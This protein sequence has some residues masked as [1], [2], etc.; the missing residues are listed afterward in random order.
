MGK[1]LVKRHD[2]SLENKSRLMLRCSFF[3]PIDISNGMAE[4]AP[5][6]FPCV[7]YGHCNT[8]SRLEAI[9][10]L[11]QL[12]LRGIGLF[13]MDFSG[14]GLSGGEYISLGWFESGDMEVAVNYLKKTGKVSCIGLWGRRFVLLTASLPHC[15]G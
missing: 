9:M 12:A 13:A 4:E 8:G 10:H 2:I 1:Y 11:E 6:P 5:H 14:S 3:E 15:P 7:I